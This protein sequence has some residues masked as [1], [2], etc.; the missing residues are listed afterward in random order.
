MKKVLLVKY[1]E[2]AMRGK[3]RSLV[4]NQLIRTIQKN[5]NAVGAINYHVT[6]EQGRLLIENMA[7]DVADDIIIP[8]VITVFGVV[9]VC[10]CI[11]TE[12]QSIENLRVVAL[13]HMNEQFGDTALS[14][15]IETRRGNKKY[16]LDSFQ[17][18]ADVGG[19]L[20]EHTKN[21]TVDVKHCDVRLRIE[22]RNKA[23]IYSKVIQ[24]FSGLPVGASG[25]ATLLLSGGI[26]S[27]VAG[28]LCAKR[29]VSI[30]AV[31]FH[32]PPYTSERAKQKVVD[33]ATRLAVFTGGVRLHV[34]SFTEIQLF[35]YER[36]Q[37]E[38]LTILLKRTMLRVAEKIALANGTQSLIMGDS[39][40]QVASQTIHSL[41]AINSAATLPILRPLAGFDKQEI[42]D[43]AK[44]IQTYEISIQPF[45]DCC[46]IFVARHPETKPKRSIIEKIESKFTEL[47]GMI[48]TAVETVEI[49]DL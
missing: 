1:G 37:T 22:L 24:G 27:P 33:L 49:L 45:E 15:K 23:Y 47:D 11:Q 36:I 4:E 32:S 17:I 31:Y 40:G 48:D 5:I 46:T 41:N 2:I 44:K 18:S 12:D 38:K 30:D 14:Y 34:V 13:L 29:G 6:K 42:V 43:L 28:F 19:Y 16:P 21:K 20:L 7:G 3:N 35:L 26:D 8:A 25:K 39:I 9:A 10:P